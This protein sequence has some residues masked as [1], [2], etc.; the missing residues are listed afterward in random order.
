MSKTK[1]YHIHQE[2]HRVA[3]IL[4]T[5]GYNVEPKTSRRGVPYIIIHKDWDRK[6]SACFFWGTKMWKVWEWDAIN[7]PIGKSDCNGIINYISDTLK[8][9]KV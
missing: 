2:I 8:K 4:L 5:N 7:T 6:I 9:N 3:D 1:N